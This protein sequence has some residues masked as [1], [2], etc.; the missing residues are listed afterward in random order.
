MD[1]ASLMDKIESFFRDFENY[2]NLNDADRLASMYSD[3]FLTAD[4]SGTRV[5]EA[6]ALRAFIPKRKQLFAGIG[7]R[8]TTL[9]SVNPS[10]LDDRY[11]LVRAE[12]R[13]EFDRDQVTVPSTYI[14]DVSGD[15]P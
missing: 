8:S 14:V 10:K 6:T 4:P 12:W 5:V 15:A 9:V 2:T 11:S 3:T 13:F 7:Y 1:Y